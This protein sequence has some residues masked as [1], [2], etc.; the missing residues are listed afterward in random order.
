MTTP[1][2]ETPEQ[3]QAGEREPVGG[4]HQPIQLP[5]PEQQPVHA[6]RRDEQDRGGDRGEHGDQ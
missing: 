6:D 4:E 3:E 5:A 1:V 2:S